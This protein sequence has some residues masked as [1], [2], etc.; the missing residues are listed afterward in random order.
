MELCVTEKQTV[1]R[2]TSLPYE[3]RMVLKVIYITKKIEIMVD[4]FKHDNIMP[5]DKLKVLTSFHLFV[6]SEF[7]RQ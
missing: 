7:A 2:E 1:D 5:V 3:I 6:H 4:S